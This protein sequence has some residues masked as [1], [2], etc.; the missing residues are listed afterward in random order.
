MLQRLEANRCNN[1]KKEKQVKESLSGCVL[2]RGASSARLA[3]GCLPNSAFGWHQANL[4]VFG[5]RTMTAQAYLKS[6]LVFSF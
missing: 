6:P 1:L 5:G 2:K 3:C 4:G